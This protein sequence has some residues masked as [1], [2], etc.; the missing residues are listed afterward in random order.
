MPPSLQRSM[1]TLPSCCRY[2][3]HVNVI[4]TATT[5]ATYCCY[6]CATAILYRPLSLFHSLRSSF[7]C[8]SCREYGHG[9]GNRDYGQRCVRNSSSMLALVPLTSIE[10]GDPWRRPSIQ[11]T[12]CNDVSTWFGADPSSLRSWRHV[13]LR[14]LQ[15][16][17]R[18][19]ESFVLI[20]ERMPSAAQFAALYML[21]MFAFCPRFLVG[22][23]AGAAA[24]RSIRRT[25]ADCL[26]A[27]ECRV[28]CVAIYGTS[29]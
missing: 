3:D 26:R 2:A 20:Y 13:R 28:Y 12:T 10:D 17:A 15:R 14:P 6:C 24:D 1:G 22:R 25:I 23:K 16:S 18:H 29:H 9:G 7:F 5:K 8:R 21:Q 19:C 4:L 11:T 27:K